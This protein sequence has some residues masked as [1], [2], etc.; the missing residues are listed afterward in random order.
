MRRRLE[1]CEDKIDLDTDWGFAYRIYNKPQV[2]NR[3]SHAY[4]HG[5]HLRAPE[6]F[7]TVGFGSKGE[8]TPPKPTTTQMT[9]TTNQ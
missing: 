5:M 9:M 4:A 6:L 8:E 2:H 1:Y 7:S 3:Y